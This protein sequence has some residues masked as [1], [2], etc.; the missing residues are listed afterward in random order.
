GVG[1]S[2][3]VQAHQGE[4]AEHDEAQPPGQH[5][6]A[7]P[8]GPVDEAGEHAGPPSYSSPPA[9]RS[10]RSS[11]FSRWLPVVTTCSPSRTSLTSTRFPWRRPGRTGRA[12][13][14]VAETRTKT[15]LPSPSD[16]TASPGTTT[17]LGRSA[18][19]IRPVP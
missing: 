19:T 3:D 4:Q 18:T 8:Q 15:R 11:D 2:V 9:M 16:C 10:F 7:V 1:E 13:K 6:E 12:S 14:P 17:T 5:E